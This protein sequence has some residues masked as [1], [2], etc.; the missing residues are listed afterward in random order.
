MIHF[1]GNN[2]YPSALE[3]VIRRFPEVAEFRIQV[4]TTRSLPVLRV[5]LEPVAA[6]G[7][8]IAERVGQAIRDELFFRVEVATVPPGTLPRF[9][10]KARRLRKA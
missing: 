7:N 3:G 5:D 2:V 6:A 1:R 4:E 10:M 9:E 8:G